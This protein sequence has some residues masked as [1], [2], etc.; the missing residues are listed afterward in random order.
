MNFYWTVSVFIG[1]SHLAVSQLT[2]NGTT[3]V[4]ENVGKM[5][6]NCS[7]KKTEKFAYPI[8]RLVIMKGTYFDLASLTL[9]SSAKSEKKD[10][11]IVANG[12]FDDTLENADLNIEIEYPTKAHAGTNYTCVAYGKN[13]SDMEVSLLGP[14]LRVVIETPSINDVSLFVASKIRELADGLQRGKQDVHNFTQVQVEMMHEMNRLS[15]NIKHVDSEKELEMKKVN[16][17]LDEIKQ[18]INTLGSNITINGQVN[19]LYITKVIQDQDKI[20]KDIDNMSINI[21]SNEEQIKNITQKQ[22]KLQQDIDSLTS[23]IENF[24]KEKEQDIKSVRQEQAQLKQEIH[25]LA[26]N[27]T[28]NEQENEE[29]I[30]K[31]VQKQDGLQQEI[32]SQTSSI[33][34]VDKQKEQGIKSVSQKQD[35]LKQVVDKLAK[36]VETLENGNKQ[37]KASDTQALAN[38]DQKT[39][40]LASSIVTVDKATKQAQSQILEIKNSLLQSSR[41]YNGPYIERGYY[42]CG[43]YSKNFPTKTDDVRTEEV[44]VSFKTAFKNMPLVFQT[45]LFQDINSNKNVRFTV[46]TDKESKTGFTGMCFTWSDSIINQ[47]DVEWIAIDVPFTSRE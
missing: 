1:C 39:S 36:S 44:Q 21:T 40:T 35:E 22:D 43:A 17:G 2:F 8:E 46:G 41:T 16:Q 25:S 4:K 18:Q 29:Q 7:F 23:S 26:I 15:T 13:E 32:H 10:W 27:V 28:S 9:D 24:D 14:A 33:E 47:L 3:I 37:Y 19:G 12:H 20:K 34:K 30:K 45:V 31:I 38:L 11:Y 42:S 6:L 5:E